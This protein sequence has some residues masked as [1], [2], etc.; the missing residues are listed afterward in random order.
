VRLPELRF[1]TPAVIAISLADG[2]R[3]ATALRERP[4]ALLAETRRELRLALALPAALVAR[5]HEA[6]RVVARLV[7]ALFRDERL[8]A[9]VLPARSAPVRS[10]AER[11]AS[12]GLDLGAETHYLASVTGQPAVAV[13]IARAGDEV[14]HAIQLVGRP[15]AD[16]ELLGLAEVVERL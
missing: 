1:C 14:P 16:D 3:F 9:L 12:P 8:D 7:R 4:D 10:R 5:A 15:F 6:R 13:P 2:H 11:E